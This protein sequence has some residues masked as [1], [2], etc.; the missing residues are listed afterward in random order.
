MLDKEMA[1]E[2]A[3]A[4]QAELGE[5]QEKLAVLQV[6]MNVIKGGEEGGGMALLLES[7]FPSLNPLY[8][9]QTIC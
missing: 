3:E 8:F 6:E 5:A 2:R 4:A 1:E 9:R 7:F